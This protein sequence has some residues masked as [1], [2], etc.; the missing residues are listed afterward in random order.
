MAF[1]TS[2][3]RRYIHIP[4]EMDSDSFIVP[5]GYGFNLRDFS[6]AC[7]DPTD[8]GASGM[9]LGAMTCKYRSGSV[10][11]VVSAHPMHGDATTVLIPVE[12][13]ERFTVA[14]LAIL[15]GIEGTRAFVTNILTCDNSLVL[16]VSI[17]CD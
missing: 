9:A 2:T 10:R 11:F 13:A 12:V 6:G 8:D 16:N 17:A 3:T 14:Q 7:I 1:V 4:D 5:D 15:A